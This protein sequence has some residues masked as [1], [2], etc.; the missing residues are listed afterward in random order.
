MRIL[1]VDDEPLDD[2]VQGGADMTGPG[3]WL[4]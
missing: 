3:G 4:C 2:L 1:N